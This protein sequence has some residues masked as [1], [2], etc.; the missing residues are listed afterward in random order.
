MSPDRIELSG[1]IAARWPKRGAD[2]VVTEISRLEGRLRRVM[3]GFFGHGTDNFVDNGQVLR[4]EAT[5]IVMNA[6]GDSF[7]VRLV[8]VFDIS[9][10]TVRVERVEFICVGP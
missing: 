4:L 3:G 1:D 5:Y 7:R 6:S 10:R 2:V 8:S 9:A